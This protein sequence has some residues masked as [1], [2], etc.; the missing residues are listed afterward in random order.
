MTLVALI[1]SRMASKE[2]PA[3]HR[4]EDGELRVI[5]IGQTF[6]TLVAGSFDEIRGSAGGNVA[7]LLR[8]LE[9]LGTIASLTD[10]AGRRRVLR[11]QADSMAELAER[12]IKSPYD[13]ARFKHKLSRIREVFY[14]TSLHE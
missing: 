13:M 11:D 4:Y 5:S 1:L 6:A 7:I 8:M 9:A 12:T 14:H 2:I 3:S 10:R